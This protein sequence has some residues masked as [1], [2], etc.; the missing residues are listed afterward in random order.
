[1]FCH[2]KVLI[3]PSILSA[4]FGR[5]A[6]DTADVLE[7]GA[8]LVHVDIMDNHF[9]PNLTIGPGVVTGLRKNLPDA[10]LDCHLM[11]DNPGS[12][13]GP[14]AKAGANLVCFHIESPGV[15]DPIALASEITGAGMIPA[16]AIKPNT[17]VSIL[18]D[19]LLSAVRMVLVMTVEPGFGGQSF[20]EDAARKC[21]EVRERAPHCAV[22][23]DGGIN[24][25]T[26]SVVGREG[27]NVIVAGSA[28][29]GAADRAT[30]IKSI[31]E[32]VESTLSL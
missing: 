3:A 26:A 12:L 30:A 29:F 17:P 22:Q 25:Q 5:L 8:D 1:M 24:P 28:V 4:D 9:V 20:M 13:V 7:K 32:G 2:G 11:V 19:E 15:T 31:R 18:T 14:L 27:A 6:E 21:R 10:F 23:V 16:V